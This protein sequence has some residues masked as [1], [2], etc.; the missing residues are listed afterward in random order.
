MAPIG[1]RREKGIDKSRTRR[2]VLKKRPVLRGGGNWRVVT[3]YLSNFKFMRFFGLQSMPFL[4]RKSEKKQEEEVEG[5]YMEP[6]EGTM[7]LNGRK[8]QLAAAV[9]KQDETASKLIVLCFEHPGSM[10]NYLNTAMAMVMVHVLK[11]VHDIEIVSKLSPTR[12]GATKGFWRDP[13]AEFCVICGDDKEKHLELRCPYNYLSP[14]AYAPCKARL[15]LWGNYTTRL[16]YKCSKHKEE[17]EDDPPKHDE[18]NL[19]RLEFLQC[20]VRVNNL[21]KRCHPEE[22]VALFSRFGPL[23][24]WHVAMLKSRACKGFGC[25]IF[26]HREHADEAIEA[27]NCCEFGDLKLRVDWAYPCL[28]C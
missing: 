18:T 2:K 5:D 7:N 24:M 12:Q 10:L 1:R 4:W 23:R 11:E 14:T 17:D 16:R 25:I 15:A 8:E 20:F 22:L 28:H 21:P 19:R 13:D 26:Q 27:L 9:Q 6:K 3:S